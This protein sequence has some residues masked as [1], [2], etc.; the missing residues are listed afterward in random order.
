MTPSFPSRRRGTRTGGGGQERMGCRTGVSWDA[1]GLVWIWW[2]T[3]PAEGWEGLSPEGSLL[4]DG[5]EVPQLHQLLSWGL[6]PR[7]Q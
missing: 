6:R 3:G 5:V 2:Y 7:A 4:H 1:G